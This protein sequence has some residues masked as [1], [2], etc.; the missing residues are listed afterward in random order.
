MIRRA[1]KLRCRGLQLRGCR[2]QGIDD[3]ADA[4]REI[5]GQPVHGGTL[6][7]F[8]PSLAFRLLLLQPSDFQGVLLE[9]LN[10]GGHRPNLVAPPL[11][12]NFD[13]Q[14]AFRQPLHGFRHGPH[15]AGDAAREEER[16]DGTQ[17]RPRPGDHQ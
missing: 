4:G 2:R 12:R 16:K 14:I 1:V 9:H 17:Q 10:G 15:G 7:G 11:G 8:G 3:F 13:L 5:I 6:V